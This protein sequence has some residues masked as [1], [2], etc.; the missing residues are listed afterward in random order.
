MA[1]TTTDPEPE[2]EGT[3]APPHPERPTRGSRF[4]DWMRSLG[5]RREPGWVGGVSAG[6]AARLGVDPLIVRGVFVVVAVLGGPA[7]LFYAAAWVLLPDTGNK[8][9]LEQLFRGRPESAIAGAGVILLASMLP[10]TQGFWYFGSQFWGNSITLG[11]IGR[12]LWTMALL[13]LI[14]VVIIV[15]ARRSNPT[16][17]P[18]V[19]LA[20][21]A[22]QSDDAAPASPEEFDSWRQ[23]QDQWKS[24]YGEYREHAA[25]ASIRAQEEYRQARIAAAAVSAER[26]RQWRAAN[27]RLRGS[28]VAI[29]LGA[30]AV[31]GAIA[32]QVVVASAAIVAGLA[33]ATLVIGI[34]I[35]VAGT[36]RRRNGFLSFVAALLLA[37][38]VVT[39]FVPTDRQLLLTDGVGISTTESGRF[40][41]PLGSTELHM[42]APAAGDRPRTIDVW[43][44]TGPTYI[45]LDAG[46]TVRVIANIRGGRMDHLTY[47]TVSHNTKVDGDVNGDGVVDEE[48]ASSVESSLE[49][50]QPVISR[51]RAE[52]TWDES[53][54]P[55]TGPVVTIRLWQGIG[56][57]HVE[58]EYPEGQ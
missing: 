14:V 35:V 24:Q 8:I 33:M 41:Q 11:S 27:P 38:T 40:A 32:S 21:P 29:A 22:G 57:V 17:P 53:F 18:P 9:H 5:I 55:G 31:G 49:L 13:G 56:D 23:Q 15:V 58:D 25:E 48:D 19:N 45:T 39:A 42:R 4:F 43:K 30:A 12:A 50:I 52:D 36:F 20:G 51:D 3:A 10:V 47:S 26:L 6:I 46:A 16:T 1:Q 28:F 2:A 54:G 7:L 34:T 44:G 37:A